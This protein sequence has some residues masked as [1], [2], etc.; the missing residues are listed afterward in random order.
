M[1][2][3]PRVN[4][5]QLFKNTKPQGL[6]PLWDLHGIRF[7]LPAVENEYRAHFLRGDKNRALLIFF[8][9][10]AS[11]LLFI[12]LGVLSG[13]RGPFSEIT[14]IQGGFVLTTAV[15]AAAVAFNTRPR[16]FDGLVFLFSLSLCVA[17]FL[18][19]WRHVAPRTTSVTNNL[20]LILILY[21]VLTSR[22]A[23]QT[24]PAILLTLE[25][26]A[27]LLPEMPVDKPAIVTGLVA[28]NLAGCL[29]SF[30][31]HKSRR[32][33]FA[34]WK[35]S[36]KAK[37]RLALS[38]EKYRT[39]VEN[40]NVGMLVAQDSGLVFVNN[41]IADFLGYTSAELLSSP[42]PFEFIHPEDRDMVFERH[43]RR[44]ENP[45]DPPD[46]Y[47]F[48][49]VSRDGDINWV[50]VTGMRLDWQGRPA[51]LN[52][53]MDITERKLAFDKLEELDTII[54]RS[55]VLVFLWANTGDRPVEF[56]SE[57]VTDVLGYSP[58]D[59][60]TGRINYADMIHPDDRQRVR[61]EADAYELE[62][63]REEFIHAPYRVITKNGA[64]RWL[65]DRTFFRKDQQGRITHHQGIV[66]DITPRRLAEEALEESR[67]TLD[68][69]L[70]ASPVGICLLENR[71]IKWGNATFEKIFGLTSSEE[72]R[73]K[74]VD[75][76]YATIEEYQ[77]VEKRTWGAHNSDRLA[78]ED[79][80]LKRIDG[81][82]FSGHIKMS[83]QDPAN[84]MEKATVT[85]SDISWRKRA[86]ADRL[87]KEK[88]QGVIE[89]AGA[90]CHEL[91]QP[92]QSVI[93]YS[94][95]LTMGLSEADPLME[96]IK[97]IEGQVN[98]MA[99]I[100]KKLM[101]HHP[102]RNHR[103][104]RHKKSSI[105]P[106]PPIYERARRCLRDVEPRDRPL[107]KSGIVF[108]HDPWS[109]CQKSVPTGAPAR[110]L[111][112]AARSPWG[113]D[114]SSIIDMRIEKEGK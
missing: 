48:R 47:T 98:R 100:T 30:H 111:R 72:Y 28:A 13:D 103:V 4:N 46:I 79:A 8:I 50:E 96:K 24:I 99:A 44:I 113:V 42:N 84:P 63:D 20:I 7:K 40:V 14:I 21:L 5:M 106:N 87:N 107:K 114:R 62:N 94:Q 17:Q 34:L 90:V 81:T 64:I 1:R 60:F 97:K 27:L 41:T 95:L 18:I 76:F 35:D 105:S 66:A 59:F 70:S 86:E 88:L 54:N 33:Q 112:P 56:V 22:W 78:E 58:E 29:T 12:F 85:I 102:L 67:N 65:E 75:M 55:P 9:A 92:L 23:L 83:Y 26:I 15:L 80:L 101:G 52:F 3:R 57:N 11:A 108:I 36:L 2:G 74:G 89:T 25:S 82:I 104:P 68:S 53:F 10:A 51:T 32:L 43:L 69:I 37:E 61:D 109:I 93:G 16:R 71:V 45:H 110:Q 39:V 91:N 77:R 73:D 38:E 31:F 49:V 19:H 6:N